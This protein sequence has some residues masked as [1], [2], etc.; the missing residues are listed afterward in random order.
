MPRST[1]PHGNADAD[2]ELMLAAGKGDCRAFERLYHKYRPLVGSYLTSLHCS[3]QAV[4]DITQEVF[5]RLRVNG[6]QFRGQCTP[7]TYIFAYVRRVLLEE[8]RLR[9]KMRVLADHLSSHR[10]APMLSSFQPDWEATRAE[11][12]EVLGRAVRELSVAQQEALRLYY[13]EQ[14]PLRDAAYA[15]HCSLRCFRGRLF[16]A[17]RRLRDLAP[18][19]LRELR[20][21]P[22]SRDD[23]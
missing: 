3:K 4:A 17:R 1:Q 11:L 15:A 6:G 2:A 10:P 16:R 9:R 20:E 23:T 22:D 8:W 12:R 13:V 21:L 5:T 18:L 19:V 14:L 7:K